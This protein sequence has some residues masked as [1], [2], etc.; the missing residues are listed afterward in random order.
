MKILVTGAA[1]QLGREICQA[2][3]EITVGIDLAQLDLTD[4]AAVLRYVAH[5]APDAVINC[6]AYTQV[7]LAET[8]VDLCRAVNAGAVAAL[9]EA[10][11]TRNCPLVQISTDYLF[12]GN[13]S[14][15]RP[16]RENDPPIPLGMYAITKFEGEQA[17]MR[18][19]K[20]LIVR[21]CGLYA[22]PSHVEA[23]NFAKTIL[24]LAQTKP[25]LRVVCDQRCTPT[26]VPHL[27]PA[28]LYLLGANGGS[29]AP[30][31]I[32]NVTNVGD[33]SWHEF[34]TE[35]VR[36]AGFSLPVHPISTAEFGAPAP[37]PAYSVLDTSAYHRLAGP[38][39]EH[40]KEALREYIDE[41]RAL[42]T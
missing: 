38:A 10:C 2:F 34:A 23:R 4:S 6:A 21:T 14:P 20:H 28:L 40:W 19:D 7:D 37:R 3:P 15:G 32:Y 17:A 13:P 16:F 31:G 33:A 42:S 9:A 11:C 29:P 35:I 27:A 26:F 24:R 18:C 41:W 25:E 30:W 1:G 12:A 39:M 5:E 36:L 8:Q 22:R